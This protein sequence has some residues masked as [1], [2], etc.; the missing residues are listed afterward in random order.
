MR[1]GE[2]YSERVLHVL[3]PLHSKAEH[4]VSR[5]GRHADGRLHGAC[6]RGWNLQEGL[7][8]LRAEQSRGR[9]F[10]GGGGAVETDG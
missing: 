5:R 9:A 8:R 4:V 2:R 3:N 6:M 7:R 1:K 10:G